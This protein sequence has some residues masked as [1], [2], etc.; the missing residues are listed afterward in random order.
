MAITNLLSKHTIL[1]GKVMTLVVTIQSVARRCTT[2]YNIMLRGGGGGGG[3]GGNSCYGSREVPTIG[4]C[5]LR[6]I[7]AVCIDLSNLY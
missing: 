5:P 2:K 1:Y 7:T 3:G 4:E 6:C